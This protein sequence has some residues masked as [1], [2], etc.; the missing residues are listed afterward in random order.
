MDA[1][2]GYRTTTELRAAKCR[3]Q[4][5]IDG[6]PG[7]RYNGREPEDDFQLR[8]ERT[9]EVSVA[10]KPFTVAGD[11]QPSFTG[12]LLR[13]MIL[14]AAD[15]VE[16]N[17]EA[18]NALNVFPVPDGDTGLNLTLTLRSTADELLAETT[19][20]SSLPDV[21]SHI[22][23]GALMGARGNSGVIVAQWLRALTQ[24]FTTAKQ[25]GGPEF[26]RALGAAAD[27]AYAAVTSPVEGTILTVARAA[28]A[29]AI[30]ALPESAEL[31]SVLAHAVEGAAVAVAH[32][33][34]LLP[35]LKAAGVVDAGGEGL[36][37]ILE[38]MLAGVRG[39]NLPAPS[40]TGQGRVDFASLHQ[41]AHDFYG[42]CTEVLFEGHGIDVP[43]LRDRIGTLG[44]CALVI[45]D[46]A[47][48]RVHV[49]TERP[50]A[51]LDLATT[52]GEL[53]HVKVDNMQRQYLALRARDNPGATRTGDPG[54]QVTG[55]VAVANGEGFA[56]VFHSLGAIVIDG[57][58]SM[59]PSV[60][61]IARAIAQVNADEVIILPNHKNVILAAERA[62][63][64]TQDRPTLLLPTRNLAQG[65]A[66][67][68]A[69]NP[70]ASAQVN[71]TALQMAAE[72]CHCLEITRA[73]RDARLSGIDIHTGDWLAI[74]DEEPAG[75]AARLDDAVGSALALVRE[76][77]L[78]L[79]TVFVGATG[80]EAEAAV[81]AN[82]IH[83]ALHIAVE[84]ALGGQPQYA[85]TIS[86]E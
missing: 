56:K 9:R 62:V 2:D 54:R 80:T 85:Y 25:V 53:L 7:A 11:T 50:G 4:L 13:V 71:A 83:D 29:S 18:L 67:A 16:R 5:S 12:S 3:P 38:G 58:Q 73:V 86:L 68:L 59:N 69:N 44:T 45:G 19:A 40:R 64:L 63:Q 32:T 78:E 48:V 55:L 74:L 22:A 66:A 84:S 17:A 52:I 76:L 41:G 8:I 82:Q 20:E 77:P 70:E 81:L 60:D 57:G 30:N 46:S 72:R 75:A 35:I 79:A 47:L 37:L 28:A 33:P 43:E 49:H 23:H 15:H 1:A 14:A 39:D 42:Y 21:V 24:S 6:S 65:L 36:R 61:E 34:E 10:A 26:A 31:E 51:V 27:A